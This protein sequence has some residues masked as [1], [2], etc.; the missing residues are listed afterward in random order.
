MVEKIK[1]IWIK[2]KDYVVKNSL[3][4]MFVTQASG[5]VAL[6]GASIYGR[7]LDNRKTALEIANLKK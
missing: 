5:G 3:N 6:M 4:I 2:S 7:I 1:S